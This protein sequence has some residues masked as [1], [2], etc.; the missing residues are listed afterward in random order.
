M[1]S[2]VHPTGTSINTRLP[3]AEHLR[4]DSLPRLLGHFTLA[5]QTPDL[6]YMIQEST[7]LLAMAE[8]SRGPPV[9]TQKSTPSPTA[10]T[11]KELGRASIYDAGTAEHDAALSRYASPTVASVPA[12][13]IPDDEDYELD[14]SSALLLLEA[15]CKSR[16]G[17]AQRNKSSSARCE[18]P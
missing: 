3:N 13:D 5:S 12:H 8:K 18:R 14:G 2:A 6:K 16:S 7:L 11:P 10:T 1:Q 9:M 15:Y 4:D 17:L